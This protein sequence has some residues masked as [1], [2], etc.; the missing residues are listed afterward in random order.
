M[1]PTGVKKRS[2]SSH[3]ICKDFRRTRDWNHYKAG[4]EAITQKTITMVSVALRWLCKVLIDASTNFKS[5]LQDGLAIFINV[6]FF[7]K[8]YWNLQWEIFNGNGKQSKSWRDLLT[9]RQL[10]ATPA[11]SENTWLILFLLLFLNEMEFFSGKQ[12]VMN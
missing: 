11:F 8:R 7:V 12:W 9:L 2:W 4:K 5:A 1:W 10:I 6:L 3:K